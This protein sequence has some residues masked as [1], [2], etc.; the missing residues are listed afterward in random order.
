M[1]HKIYKYVKGKEKDRVCSILVGLDL[2]LY[3]FRQKNSSCQPSEKNKESRHDIGCQKD[4]RTPTIG[5]SEF[6]LSFESEY[7][8]LVCSLGVSVECSALA[9]NRSAFSLFLNQF[10]CVST[11]KRSDKLSEMS[12]KISCDVCQQEFYDGHLNKHMKVH[13]RNQDKK[14][15]CNVCEKIFYQEHSLSAHSSTVYLETE[16]KLKKKHCQRRK[17][18]RILSP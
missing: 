12:E 18:P 10:S 13:F 17:G 7:Y 15:E 14:Y 4:L 6:T 11:C 16:V 9:R 8:F 1:C 3:L 5:N 2:Q